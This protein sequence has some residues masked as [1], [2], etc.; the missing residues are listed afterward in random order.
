MI[1]IVSDSRR[2]ALVALVLQLMVVSACGQSIRA[3]GGTATQPAA[4]EGPALQLHERFLK[5]AQEGNIDLLFLGDSITQ[6]WNNNEVWQRYYAPRHAANFG[7][8]GDRTQHVLWRLDHGEV[9]GIKPKVVV[10]LIGT[11]NIGHGVNTVDE[12]IIGIEAVVETL[13][14]KLPDSK[15]LLLGVFPRA[16]SRE[17]DATEAAPDPRTFEI[18][19]RIAKLDDGKMVKFLDIS[20]HFLNEEGKI[21]KELMPDFLH[22]SS[23]GYRI[24][25]EA[26]EP[27][28]WEMMEGT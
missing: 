17:K 24:W 14:A 18:N 12:T 22:L 21:P 2:L 6:G 10:L 15:I 27:T 20:Q 11:N 9:D 28:L 26:M 7:I 5:Q 4:R 19:K 25:A 3:K 23:K 8:G 13:R 1:P 16:A